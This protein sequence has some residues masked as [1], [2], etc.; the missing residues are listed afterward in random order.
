MKLPKNGLGK[1]YPNEEMLEQI[2]EESQGPDSTKFSKSWE[3]LCAKREV[4][5]KEKLDFGHEIAQ[6]DLTLPNTDLSFLPSSF[7]REEGRKRNRN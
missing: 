3:K 7:W 4:I 2:C 5:V 6:V 1:L